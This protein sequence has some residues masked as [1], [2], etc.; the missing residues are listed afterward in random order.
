LRTMVVDELSPYL[1]NG[2]ARAEI[3]GPSLMLDPDPAQAIAMA[4]HELATNAVKYGALSVPGGRVKVDWRLRPGSRLTIRWSERG[5]PPVSPPSRQGFGTRVMER[6]VC[7]QCNGE[8]EFD[9]RPDGVVCEITVV[10]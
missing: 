1:E 4:V 10:T 9:W 8:L 2:R 6:M 7:G 3:D 5:G